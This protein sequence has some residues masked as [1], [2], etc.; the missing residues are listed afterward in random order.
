MAM[1]AH[2]L[3]VVT[4]AAALLPEL[5]AALA[6]TASNDDEGLVQTLRRLLTQPHERAQLRQ[7]AAQWHA[8][9]GW[10]QAVAEHRLVYTQLGVE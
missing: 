6:F 10:P 5:A 1:L 3:P 4:T 2:H 7:A 9:H 8:G